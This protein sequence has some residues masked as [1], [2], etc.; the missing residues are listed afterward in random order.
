[1][2]AKNRVLLCAQPASRRLSRK[3]PTLTHMLRPQQRNSKLMPG[4]LAHRRICDVAITATR[5][6]TVWCQPPLPRGNK[7]AIRWGGASSCWPLRCSVSNGR[8]GRVSLINKKMYSGVFTKIFIF[9]TV[10]FCFLFSYFALV[11]IL[12]ARCERSITS[13]N[14]IMQATAAQADKR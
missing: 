12:R 5:S 8:L 6:K 4:T 7:V 2:R 11:Y 1:M 14:A 9:P 10:L 3:T 13:N